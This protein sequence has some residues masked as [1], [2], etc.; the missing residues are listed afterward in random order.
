VVA[1]EAPP[2][3]AVV[4]VPYRSVPVDA[5]VDVVAFGAGVAVGSY[6]PTAAVVAEGAVGEA[7]PATCV[8]AEGVKAGASVLG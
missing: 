5:I 2:V 8:T 6:G 1:G 4:P 3:A 7:V